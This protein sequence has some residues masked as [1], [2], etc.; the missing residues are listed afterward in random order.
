MNHYD[1][2]DD[3][4]MADNNTSAFND[5][6]ITGGG[7]V[8]LHAYGLAI[9]INPI[10]NPYAKRSGA[11]LM[12]SPPSGVENANRLDDRPW[13]KPR[14]GMAEKVID[15]F[16]D[17]GFLTWGGYWDDPIDYQH[18]QV[19]RK[20]AEELAGLAPAQAAAVLE[21]H[22]KRYRLCRSAAARGKASNRS[23]CIVDNDANGGQTGD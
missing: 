20:L 15:V 1:G 18:F 7:A 16:A 6:A 11:T 14:S 12:F 17:H 5:R 10:Q 8:S 22:V 19:S 2:N 13:K 9:D 23:K 3:A 4:S 21:R